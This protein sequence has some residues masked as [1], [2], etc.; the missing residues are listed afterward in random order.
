MISSV[1]SG[2][3]DQI[4]KEAVDVVARY[5][6]CE[7]DLIDVLQKIDRH[8]VYHALMYRSLF[9]YA[10]TGLGLSEEVAYAFINIARKAKEV[11]ELKDEI[12]KGTISVNK[13]RRIVSVINSQNQAH[14][15]NLAKNCSKQKLEREIA[16]A[17]PLQ[18]VA[19]RLA[20]VHP[21]S[22][23]HEK[24]KILKLNNVV[25]VQLQAGI[26]EGLMLDI[27]RVQD[28][29]SQK[30]RRPATLEDVL[31]A[32]TESFLRKDDP[33]RMAERH[34]IRRKAPAIRGKVAPGGPR[35]PGGASTSSAN[36]DPAGPSALAAAQGPSAQASTTPTGTSPVHA[37]PTSVASPRPALTATLKHQVI[38]KYQGQCAFQNPDGSR[39]GEKRFL[40]I[41]HIKPVSAGGKNEVQ[42]LKL[43]C[44]GH[45][46]MQHH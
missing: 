10:T 25:R 30:L 7:I 45:H 20:Y 41:H 22:E 31:K 43:L 27:R 6:T 3:I 17:S 37:R 26:S 36:Q 35:A 33:I 16:I 46:K 29:V 24:T 38:H 34:Q 15:L 21:D 13:A 18:A 39:C 42:N 23:I 40:E 5:K 32:L 19:D 9:H 4:H 12:R 2:L 28:I 14:W 44:S 8:R 11:P 1:Q